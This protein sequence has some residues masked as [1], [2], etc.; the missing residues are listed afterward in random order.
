[1]CSALSEKSIL[2]EKCTSSFIFVNLISIFSLTHEINNRWAMLV[3]SMDCMVAVNMDCMVPVLSMVNMDCMVSMVSM[4][5]DMDL[6][7][8]VVALDKPDP[9]ADH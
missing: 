5:V 3:V 2:N 7:N 9:L 1:M 6:E 8:V 4:M